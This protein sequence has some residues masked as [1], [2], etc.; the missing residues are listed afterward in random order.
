M[1]YSI[2]PSLLSGEVNA[3]ASKSYAH[4]ALICAALSELPTKVYMSSSSDDIEATIGCLSALG[5]EFHPFS[6]GI[7]VVPPRSF[8]EEAAIDCGECGSTLRF[9]LPISAVLNGEYRFSGSGR[10]AQRPI[11]PLLDE[12]AKHGA[13]FSSD[14]LPLTVSGRICGGE[15][16][17]PGNISSQFFSGLMFALPLTNSDCVIRS[18]GPLQSAQYAF[19]TAGTLSDF[20]VFWRWEESENAFFLPAFQRRRFSS[21]IEYRVEGDWSN[22]AFFLVA[23]AIGGAVRVSGLFRDSAQSDRKIIDIIRQTGAF[24]EQ[25]ED[26]VCVK[27]QGEL[28]PF[29]AGVSQCPD[30]FCILAVLAAACKGESVISGIERLRIKESDRIESTL[31][32]LRGLGADASVV[33]VGATEKVIVRGTSALDG[34]IVDSFN[35]HRI[36][37]SAAIAS[38]ICKDSV[39]IG[40]AQ[41]VNKSYPRFSCDFALLGGNIDVI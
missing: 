27:R 35:D 24:V 37:M 38:A 16:I 13:R 5:A 25:R 22:A 11:K 20:G 32:M 2:K 31:A 33:G 21:A 19:M 8:A 3:I 40:G 17:I 41:A 1:V 18:Q 7:E 14:S 10:L 12:L 6:S 39:V 29:E 30:L 28:L 23:G 36:V 4:R 9:L 15:Y 26:S 34:G